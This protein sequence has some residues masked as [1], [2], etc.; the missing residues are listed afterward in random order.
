MFG[1]IYSTYPLLREKYLRTAHFQ[2]MPLYDLKPTMPSVGG[3]IHPITATHIIKDIGFDVMLAVG[4]AIQGHPGGAAAGGRAMR[5]AI[6]A[7]VEGIP[8]LEQAKEHPEL[9]KALELWG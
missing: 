6:D 1:S 3:G 7:V 9:R 5:Q 4:G 2:T 8:L